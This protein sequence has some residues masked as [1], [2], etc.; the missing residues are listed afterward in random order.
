MQVNNDQNVPN[1]FDFNTIRPPSDSNKVTLKAEI[2][3]KNYSFTVVKADVGKLSDAEL[4]SQYGEKFAK[5][6]KIAEVVDL[7]AYEVLAEKKEK[8]SLKGRMNEA[9]GEME[10]TET[11]ALQGQ[12]SIKL[13]LSLKAQVETI[14]QI[15]QGEIN[16]AGNSQVKNPVA[17]NPV[18]ENASQVDLSEQDSSVVKNKEVSLIL[19]LVEDNQVEIPQVEQKKVEDTANK[20]EKSKVFFGAD[21]KKLTAGAA[22]VVWIPKADQQLKPEYEGKVI[23][24]PVP[25]GLLNSVFKLKEKEI[26]EEAVLQGNMIAKSPDKLGIVEPKFLAVDM[27]I[28][29]N[30]DQFMATASKALGDLD[31][32]IMEPSLTPLQAAKLGLGPVKGMNELHKLGYAA[33]DVKSE[34]TLG[35]VAKPEDGVGDTLV[36]LADFGKAVEMEADE[37]R[38]FYSGNKAYAPPERNLSQKGD[39]FGMGMITLRAMEERIF[40]KTGTT[41][42]ERLSK[43]NK[44]G[45]RGVEHFRSTEKSFAKSRFD[46]FFPTTES[47]MRRQERAMNFYVNEFIHQFGQNFRDDPMYDHITLY[48][49]L[50]KET[51]SSDPSKRPTAAQ[52]EERYVAF[53]DTVENAV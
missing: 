43:E 34:N 42:L 37:S 23:Y 48:T 32:L 17:V 14:R 5:M 46:F 52:F 53:L 7:K 24:T 45:L 28:I 13:P 29:E 51:F 6:A 33:G 1:Q 44:T 2:K 19:E 20:V 15:Y 38:F 35:Y 47:N 50:L 39:V 10:K 36:K 22:K 12:I 3:G 49:T 9:D 4:K 26:R 27:K 25:D 18:A 30:D 8:L 41:T 21:Y 40:A 31:S 16:Q 11:H